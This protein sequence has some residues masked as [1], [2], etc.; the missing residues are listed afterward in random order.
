MNPLQQKTM[1]TLTY[2]TLLT[3]FTILARADHHAGKADAGFKPIFDGKSLKHWNGDPKFWSVQDGAI[4]GQTTRETPTKGNTFIIW[5][6]GKPADFELKLKFKISA[7]NSGIQIRSFK[8]DGPDEWRI[9]G[10]QSDFEAGDTWSGTLYGERFGGVFAKRGQRVTVGA[11]GKKTQGEPVGNP[12]E[13]NKAIKKGDWNEYHIIAKGN[14]IKQS[15]N[16]TLMAEVTDNGPKNRSDGLIALQL[17]AGPPMKVQFKEIMLKE[18][19]AQAANDGSVGKTKICYVSH[20]GSHGRGQHEYAA[21]CRLMGE[22]LEKAYPGKVESAYSINWPSDPEK[23]FEGADTVVFFCTGGGGHL[24]NRHV[25]EFDKLMRKGIGIACLHYGVEVPIGPSGKGMLNWMGG[26]FQAHWSVNPHW[27]ANFKVFPNHPAANGIKPF[28]SNDEW[29]FHMKFRSNM[30]GVTP[31]L[32]AVAPDSTMKRRDGAHSGNP[33]VRK[34][35]AAEEPQHV[36]WCYQR[37]AEYNEGRGFGF[38]G[39][40]YHKNWV[41]DNF[42][43]TVLN[44]VAWT[45][46]LE[47]P[48]N[49][50]LSPTP[51]KEDLEESMRLVY[52]TQK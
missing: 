33:T 35:V 42:R 47:I 17:H 4:T 20:K 3:L 6:G 5:E 23:F 28:E 11:D 22:W 45:A 51:T 8:V 43:K 26:F 12:A 41:D 52:N 13:L 30:E 49:G 36:A 24:V 2:I 14:H 31:I 7:G 10:Y 39:L 46:R 48:G 37:G 44:G 25:A 34:A 1:K 50:V 21:G 19:K 9:G 40:H 18:H 16:G 15:I 38:T 29:Y 27:V 32:S